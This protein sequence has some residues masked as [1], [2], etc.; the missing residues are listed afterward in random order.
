MQTPEMGEQI[1]T[2]AAT[3]GVSVAQIARD[4]QALGLPLIAAH[5]R[6]AGLAKVPA[7]KSRVKG[8]IPAAV[9]AAPVGAGALEQ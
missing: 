2:L 5:Y 7:T 8:K 1:K 6:K 3:Y 9:F 4:A